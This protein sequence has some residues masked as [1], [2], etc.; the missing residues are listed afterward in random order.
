MNRYR[1]PESDAGTRPSSRPPF[2]IAL[3]LLVAG[4]LAGLALAARLPAPTAAGSPYGLVQMYPNPSPTPADEFGSAVAWMPPGDKLAVAAR[5]DELSGATRVGAIYMLDKNSG[6]VVGILSRGGP[7]AKEYLGYSLDVSGTEI[8]AGA[9]HDS[10]GAQNAGAAYLF[11]SLTGSVL[12]TF[13]NPIP[14]AFD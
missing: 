13:T 10:N 2:R 4:L 11:D 14:S 12:M 1:R 3:L 6:S 5:S 7:D 8:L 9:P